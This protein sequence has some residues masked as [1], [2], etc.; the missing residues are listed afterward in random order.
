MGADGSHGVGSTAEAGLPNITGQQIIGWGD[1]TAP[2]VI[3]TDKDRAG[4][5]GATHLGGTGNVWNTV[6]NSAST[7][8]YS[9]AVTFNASRSNS[10]Y[11]NSS[12]VQPPALFVY[13][14]QRTG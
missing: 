7:N 8:N 4:A 11:G 5:L 13:F 1:N 14:W 6:S 10:I 12:T 3:L 2:Q 9:N